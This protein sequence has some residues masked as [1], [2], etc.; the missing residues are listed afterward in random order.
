LNFLGTRF[1][2]HSQ[3]ISKCFR[4]V[5]IGRIASQC[6]NKKF[7]ILKDHNEIEYESDKFEE[8]KM[9]PLEDCNDGEVE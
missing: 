8:G 9:L 1:A 3:T 4:C 5:G 6:P 7:M 2:L